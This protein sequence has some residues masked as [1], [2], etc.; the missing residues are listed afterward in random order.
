[1]NL[2]TSDQV[3]GGGSSEYKCF[4]CHELGDIVQLKTHT[5]TQHEGQGLKVIRFQS[6]GVSGYLECQICG[7]LSPGFE[8]SKQ[9]AHFH[10]EHPLE[11]YNSI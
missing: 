4:Y 3:S 10:D 5:E 11:V 6:R 2:I 7:Y 1:M 9:K 8:K